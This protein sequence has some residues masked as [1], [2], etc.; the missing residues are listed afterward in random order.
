MAGIDYFFTLVSPWVYLGHDAFLETA[1]RHGAAVRFRPVRL[2][3]VWE[4]SGAI[5][6][7]QRPKSRQDYRLVELQRWRAKRGLPLNLRPKHFPTN[8]ALADR[9]VAALVLSGRDPAEA[10]RRISRALWVEEKDIADRATLAA[11]LSAAGEDADSVLE[12]AE[13]EAAAAPIEENTQA[14]IGWSVVGVPGYVLAGEPFWGQDRIDLLDE[15]LASG[16]P[17]FRSD[18]A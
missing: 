5:P 10:M 14:A 2:A 8:P 18:A 6:L 4:R 3:A 13:G 7:A 17:P 11:A 16:R 1:A 9:A 15:A 12:A